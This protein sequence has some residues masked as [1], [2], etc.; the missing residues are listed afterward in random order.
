M[1]E[2][3][4]EVSWF[5]SIIQW[6]GNKFLGLRTMHVYTMLVVLSSVANPAHLLCMC[7]THVATRMHTHTYTHTCMHACTHTY[8]RTHARTHACTHTHTH[9]H[10]HAHTHVHTHTHNYAHTDTHIIIILYLNCYFLM[11]RVTGG[12]W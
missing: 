7:T 1:S 9:T 12:M 5:G 4:S 8:T 11:C 2:I 10:E 3:H 6:N